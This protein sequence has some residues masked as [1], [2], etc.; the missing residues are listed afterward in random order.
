MSEYRRVTRSVKHDKRQKQ[1]RK[2]LFFFGLSI[3]FLIIF[4][5]L[6]LFGNKGNPQE[7]EVESSE[8]EEEHTEETGEADSAEANSEDANTSDETLIE[9]IEENEENEESDITIEE[10]ESDDENVITAFKGDWDPVGTE[11]EGPHTTTYEDG[12]DDRLEIRRA[13]VMVT[14]IKED[15]M[16]EHWIGRGGDQEV[17]AT[18]SDHAQEDYYRVYLRWV[19]DEGWQ[20]TKADKLKH[21]P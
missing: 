6:L 4:I 18:V 2:I 5:S 9:E 21:H 1:K 10:I 16:I 14:G 15:D 19:D 20:P 17:I 12:S 7:A 11:Q 3:L 13:L 8:N